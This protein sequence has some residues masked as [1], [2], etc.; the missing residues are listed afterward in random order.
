VQLRLCAEGYS[1]G[2]RKGAR[3][4]ERTMKQDGDWSDKKEE[5][6]ENNEEYRQNERKM[7]KL[8]ER[9]EK[10]WKKGADRHLESKK[11]KRRE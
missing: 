4:K 10:C 7:K 6:K 1:H 5:M 9:K 2:Q 3:S 11:L 8:K